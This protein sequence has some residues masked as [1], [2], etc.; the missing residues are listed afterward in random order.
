SAILQVYDASPDPGGISDAVAINGILTAAAH[1]PGV[2]NLSFGGVQQDPFLQDAVLTAVHNGCLVVAAA[3]NDGEL[4]SPAA[5]PAA[6]PHMF[7][8]GASDEH[9]QVASFS[10]TGPDLDLVAPGVG[11][12]GAVPLTRDASG[13]E[14]DAGTSVASLIYARAAKGTPQNSR[15]C[16][17]GSAALA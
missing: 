15:G 4:G 7:T 2:I 3:G 6:W 13:Y 9:D 10:T 12:T 11:I 1:C 5:Y 8:V 17:V 16:G 14:T